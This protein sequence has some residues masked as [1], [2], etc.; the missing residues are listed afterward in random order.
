M[1]KRNLF[2]KNIYGI[3]ILGAFLL[4]GCAGIPHDVTQ[5]RPHIEP[6]A[7]VLTNA[8]IRI[9]AADGSF[10]I[11]PNE[12]FS[13]PFYS[14]VA[15]CGSAFAS[16]SITEDHVPAMACGSRKVLVYVDGQD[17]PLYGVLAL[18]RLINSAKGPARR[19]YLI[20][21]PEDK[22]NSAFQGLTTVSYEKY[23]WISTRSD[24]YKQTKNWRSWILWL[25]QTPLG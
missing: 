23:D 5:M 13:P 20:K 1:I 7:G 8:N 11:K 10:E 9:V 4:S 21:I 19:S 25:S 2:T 18:G 3:V 15:D 6:V 12:Q 24:G 22:I 16:G 17:Q 14:N